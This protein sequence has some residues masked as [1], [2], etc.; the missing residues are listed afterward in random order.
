[1]KIISWNVNGIRSVN[2]KGFCD[3]VTQENPDILCLQEVRATPDQIP[4]EILNLKGY[5]SLWFSAQKKGYSGTGFLFKAKPEEVIFGFGIP[6]FDDE[7]RSIT[8]VY[9]DYVLYTV[10][11]P[12]GSGSDSRLDYKMRFYDAFLED[13]EKWIKNG[14]Q[15]IACGD[16]NTCHREIDIARPKA[17]EKNSGFLPIER[18]W[19][20]QYCAKGYVDAFRFFNPEAKDEYT[21][22]SNRGGA[23]AKNIGWRIDYF[24]VNQNLTKRLISSFI[25]QKIMGSDHCPIGLEL[26]DN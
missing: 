8:L 10:Y 23:R 11:F 20:D 4:A 18:A 17:N 12:N 19:I 25:L 15:V 1:M 13:S 24:F 21:W 2:N 7:G 6:E 22:W 9:K 3:F 5:E 14:Y 16:Y 26:E